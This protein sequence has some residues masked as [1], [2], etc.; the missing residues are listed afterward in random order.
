[1]NVI[2]VTLADTTEPRLIVVERLVPTA[3]NQS[4]TDEWALVAGWITAT[5]SGPPVNVTPKPPAWILLSA[6][7]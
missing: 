4:V 6:T 2:P 3:A 1:M 5:P 7:M